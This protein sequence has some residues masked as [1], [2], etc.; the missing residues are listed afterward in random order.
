MEKSNQGDNEITVQVQ[1][2]IDFLL[3][4]SKKQRDKFLALLKEVESIQ[5]SNLTTEEKAKEIKKV[6]WSKRSV[7]GKLLIGAFLGTI[8][9][10][11]IFGTGG[12][13]IAGLGG[14]IGVWGWLAGAA[15]GVLVSSLIQNFEKNKD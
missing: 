5:K 6:L 10:L 4:L 15:G 1:K 11:V 8:T 12:I 13:G 7:K 3:K 14:A 2:G 9:G